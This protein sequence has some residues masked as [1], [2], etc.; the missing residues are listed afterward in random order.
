[1]NTE[2]TRIR[3]EEAK[4]D[5]HVLRPVDDVYGWTDPDGEIM[6]KAVTSHGDPVELNLHEARIVVDALLTL[7]A[8]IS[9]SDRS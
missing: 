1:M 7:I 2:G 9:E 4:Q 3:T 8:R 6:F 5:D